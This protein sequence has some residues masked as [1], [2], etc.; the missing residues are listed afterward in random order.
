MLK[1]NKKEYEIEEEIQLLNEKDEIVFSFD[2]KLT[3]DDLQKLKKVLIGKDTLKLASKIKSFENSDLDEE[4]TNEII[5][6]A[7]N[8][9]KETESLIGK[10]CFK[11]NKD[12]FIELGGQA[13][14][15]EMVEV[16]SDFLLGFFIKKQTARANT[17]NTDLAKIST[18]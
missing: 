18:K 10:L 15:E 13:K 17:I 8:M 16:I 1:I 6:L 9:N 11:D 3:A 5:E 2:M 7:D 4:K 12:K 14:Y